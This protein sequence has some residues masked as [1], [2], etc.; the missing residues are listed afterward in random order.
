[1]VGTALAVDHVVARATGQ[2][3]AGL[4]AVDR[5]VTRAAVGR[6]PDAPQHTTGGADQ[7]AGVDHVVA[8]VV[9]RV[10]KREH[11]FVVLVVAV[12]QVHERVERLV[13]ELEPEHV[14]GVT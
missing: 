3:V 13:A 1:M 6:D 2:V 9:E 12:G 5:V 7:V 10:G 4:A 11:P 8:E 14:V